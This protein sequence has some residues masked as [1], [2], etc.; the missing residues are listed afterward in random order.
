MFRGRVIVAVS[1]IALAIGCSKRVDLPPVA[2]VAFN[3]SSSR[4]AIGSPVD[5]TYKFEVLPNAVINGD[6]TIF[7]HFIDARGD[8]IWTDDHDPPLKTSQWK[9]GQTIGPYTRT[10]FIPPLRYI[11]QTSV[12]IGLYKPGGDERLTL[13]SS[14]SEEGFAK[15]H[16]YKVGE[17]EVLPAM[18]NF[19]FGRGWYDLDGDPLTPDSRWRWTQQSATI[20]L[21]NPKRDVT[22]Y[23]EAAARTEAFSSPQTVTIVANGQPVTTFAADNAERVVRRIPISALQLGTGD[24]AEIRID[25]DRTFNPSKLPVRSLDNREL[26]LLVFNLFVEAK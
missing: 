6:Y 25:V 20:T 7:V 3:A 18:D 8:M 4:V 13:T 1:L 15:V 11:G 24:I 12:V 21:R 2:G 17:L 19:K 9:P 23:L 5:F 16:E 14:A 26:G 22:F 10:R